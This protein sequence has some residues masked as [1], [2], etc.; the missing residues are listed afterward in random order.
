MLCELHVKLRDAP[1]Y[2]I[3]IILVSARLA[4]CALVHTKLRLYH[5]WLEW[6]TADFGALLPAPYSVRIDDSFRTNA[7]ATK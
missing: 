4:C 2:I 3:Y 5:L 6:S 7:A 1:R